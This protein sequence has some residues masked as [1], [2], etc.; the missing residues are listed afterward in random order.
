MSCWVSYSQELIEFAD[1]ISRLAFPHWSISVCCLCDLPHHGAGWIHQDR[2][3]VHSPPDKGKTSPQRSHLRG[4]LTSWKSCAMV[5]PF[6]SLWLWFI[7]ITL[8]YVLQVHREHGSWSVICYPSHVCVHACLPPH[9]KPH[10]YMHKMH[11]T[12]IHTHIHWLRQNHSDKH[13]C[14]QVTFNQ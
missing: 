10:E 14:T 13:K 4:E 2:E 12:D 6:L 7:P 9:T 5:A 8:H 11:I 1:L 3:P